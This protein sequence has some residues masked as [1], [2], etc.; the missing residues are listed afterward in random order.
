MANE[1]TW[2]VEAECYCPDLIKEYEERH[3]SHTQDV[4]PELQLLPLLQLVSWFKHSL[5]IIACTT[6]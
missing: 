4:Q 3:S 6:M 2:K 1:D 5:Y